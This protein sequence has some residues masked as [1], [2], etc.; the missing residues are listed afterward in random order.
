VRGPNTV[1]GKNNFA[2]SRTAARLPERKTRV[3]P[4]YFFGWI[5]IVDVL[6]SPNTFGQL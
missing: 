5:L 4:L 1:L 3:P 2:V 6:N